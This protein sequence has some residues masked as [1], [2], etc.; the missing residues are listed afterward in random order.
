MTLTVSLHPPEVTGL[1][2]SWEAVLRPLGVLPRGLEVQPKV[3]E[4]GWV[5]GLRREGTFGVM[6]P[7]PA[8]LFRVGSE[9]SR[10]GHITESGAPFWAIGRVDEGRPSIHGHL[11]SLAEAV[12]GWMGQ[13]PWRC[14]V[15]GGSV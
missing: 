11:R 1:R 15:R 5:A 6:Y 3:R 4:L 9:A 2:V 7:H 14:D 12:E 10:E 8:L 13:R